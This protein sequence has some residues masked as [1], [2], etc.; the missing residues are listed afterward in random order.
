MHS[1]RRNKL[2]LK[3]RTEESKGPRSMQNEAFIRAIGIELPDEA[4]RI[5]RQ[6]PSLDELSRGERQVL[7]VREVL[8]GSLINLAYLTYLYTVKRVSDKS[9][10]SDQAQGFR[11]YAE[12]EIY[13]RFKL[14]DFAIVGPAEK[15]GAR[16][17]EMAPKLVASIYKVHGFHAVYSLLTPLFRN[18]P[19][20]LDSAYKTLAQEYAQSKRLSPTY[21]TTQLDGPDHQARFSSVIRIGNQTATG[22]GTSK[23]RAESAAAKQFCERNHIA[24][25]EPKRPTRQRPHTSASVD[26]NRAKALN[27]AAKALSLPPASVSLK[28]FDICMTHCSY[29]EQ[30]PESITNDCLKTIGATALEV[31]CQDYVEMRY[32]PEKL[33]LTNEKIALLKEQ[34]L[35]RAVPQEAVAV[36]RRGPAYGDRARINYD[37]IRVEIAKSILCCIF[38]NYFASRDET[39]LE[40]LTTLATSFLDKAAAE[41]TPDYRTIAQEIVQEHRLS[42]HEE[43][44]FTDQMDADRRPICK[45][46]ISIGT[47]SWNIQK[48]GSGPSKQRAREDALKLII[49]CLMSRC[50]ESTQKAAWRDKLE[51]DRRKLQRAVRK[52]NPP[53]RDARQKQAQHSNSRQEESHHEPIGSPVGVVEPHAVDKPKKNGNGARLAPKGLKQ[54]QV[55]HNP[56]KRQAQIKSRLSGWSDLEINAIKRTYGEFGLFATYWQRA[57]KNRTEKDIL[58]AAMLLDVIPSVSG[59]SPTRHDMELVEFFRTHALIDELHRKEPR[60]SESDL[61]RAQELCLYNKKSDFKWKSNRRDFSSGSGTSISRHKATE[62]Y[63]PPTRGDTG[64]IW[65]SWD[66]YIFEQ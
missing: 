18:P 22:I 46:S 11:G 38:L 43:F 30:H 55:T 34:C 12:R 53:K 47:K 29:E 57:L 52:P 2:L 40:A 35:A 33:S 41:A 64:P 63:K 10:L 1:E 6:H 7:A 24:P 54:R 60:L 15:P 26:S 65:D 58:S 4:V 61:E 21:T 16:R 19:K 13:E 39:E 8:G 44:R 14:Q 3:Q 42:Y 45:A 62:R 50:P 28:Q 49:P 23:K 56:Q 25:S 59:C 27:Q 66:T 5:V 20:M 36:Y 31:L 32:D 9:Q 17:E 48:T 51:T 37:A